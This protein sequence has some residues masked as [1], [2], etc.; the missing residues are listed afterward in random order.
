MLAFVGIGTIEEPAVGEI[1]A[2][3]DDGCEDVAAGKCGTGAGTAVEMGMA[4]RV[5][6]VACVHC[7]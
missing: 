6:H 5:S 7:T 3:L 4:R 2:V 1:A